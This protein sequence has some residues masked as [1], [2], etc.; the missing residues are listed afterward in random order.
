[1]NDQANTAAVDEHPLAGHTLSGADT[2]GRGSVGTLPPV[3]RT[4]VMAEV[5]AGQGL[6]RQAE[7]LRRR[8]GDGEDG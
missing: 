6:K 3:F 2:G 7:Q 1:M 4:K 5:L 8:L